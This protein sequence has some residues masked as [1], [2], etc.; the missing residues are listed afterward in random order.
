MY[1]SIDVHCDFPLKSLAD[2][3]VVNISMFGRLCNSSVFIGSTIYDLVD[4]FKLQIT[5]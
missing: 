5:V 4:N 3:S 1:L 2:W